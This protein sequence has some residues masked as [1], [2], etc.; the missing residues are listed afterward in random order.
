MK[1]FNIKLISTARKDIGGDLIRWKVETFSEELKS[2]WG[3]GRGWR[4]ALG[5]STTGDRLSS[6]RSRPDWPSSVASAREAVVQLLGWNKKTLMGEGQRPRRKQ[7]FPGRPSRLE[8]K[9]AFSAPESAR[10]KK[11]ASAPGLDHHCILFLT[12]ASRETTNVVLAAEQWKNFY[13]KNGH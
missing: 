4:T 5:S 6:P 2:W 1:I 11:A 10:P 12:A 9:M 13:G 8:R 7:R 3:G